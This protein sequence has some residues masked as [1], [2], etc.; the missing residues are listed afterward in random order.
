MAL[1]SRKGSV[2]VH[3]H[4]HRS[5]YL[6]LCLFCPQDPTSDMALVSR[7]GSVVVHTQICIFETMFVLPPGP[8]IRHGAG[9]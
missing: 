6:R 7:K 8:H 2:V 3:T 9:V 4:T 5:V 1:V